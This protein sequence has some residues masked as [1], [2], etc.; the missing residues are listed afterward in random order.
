MK[1]ALF[2]G[3]FDPFTF[4][5]L[6][7][8]KR[9]SQIFEKV[10][11]AVGNNPDKK[12]MFSKDER[13]GFIKESTKN[14]NV[15]VVDFPDNTLTTD[16]AYEYNAVLIKGVRINADFDYEKMMHEINQIHHAGVETIIFPSHSSLNFISSSAA[17]QVCQHFGETEKFVSPIVKEALEFKIHK[18]KRII[19]TGGIASGKS[20]IASSIEFSSAH[21]MYNIDLDKI[22][23][24]ILFELQEPLYQRL[25]EELKHELGIKN[26]CRE[27]VSKTVFFDKEKLSVL[28]EAMRQPMLTRIRN[29]TAKCGAGVVVY[30]GALI[31]DAG[32][33]FL[34]NNKIVLLFAE[35][36]DIKTRLRERGYPEQEIE[37]KLSSQM[38][39]T[40]K[41]SHAKKEIGL[42]GGK[43]LVFNTSKEFVTMEKIIKLM[44][45][46]NLE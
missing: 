35:E 45:D 6:D 16:M 31:L 40:E 22:A 42:R 7:I 24:E 2:V 19:L 33:G 46:K 15:E 29:A 34:G 4:G 44:Y 20:T 32:W 37:A 10:I 30:N 39:F 18:Q 26:W 3:S 25:R 38:S 36:H 1:T 9:A 5:H 11:V 21:P 27:E 43:L 14:L 13:K 28:N 23:F 41:M 8:V 12:Y 17:K